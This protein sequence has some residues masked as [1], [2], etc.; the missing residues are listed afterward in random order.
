MLGK[1]ERKLSVDQEWVNKQVRRARGC[2]LDET[3]QLLYTDQVIL[4]DGQE[5]TKE[6][7]CPACAHVVY[8]PKECK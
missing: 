2:D 3:K 4:K 6:F 8:N 1:R 5:F 7:E